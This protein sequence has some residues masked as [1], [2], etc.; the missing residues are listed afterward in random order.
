MLRELLQEHIF[1]QL[2]AVFQNDFARDKIVE[3]PADSGVFP[4]GDERVLPRDFPLPVV[5]EHIDFGMVAGHGHVPCRQI[6]RPEHGFH[7]GGCPVRN[8]HENRQRIAAVI[9]RLRHLP[10]PPVNQNPHPFVFLKRD[11]LRRGKIVHDLLQ[12]HKPVRRKRGKRGIL[13]KERTSKNRG[14]RTCQEEEFHNGLAF[15]PESRHF[16]NQ[17]YTSQGREESNLLSQFAC[18]GG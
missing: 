14:Q 5:V 7:I 12:R 4:L 2:V 9:I 13:G 8:P 11:I 17:K 3:C 18:P 1:L 6:V 15:C 10:D 16:T